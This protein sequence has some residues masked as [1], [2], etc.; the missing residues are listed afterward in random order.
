MLIYDRQYRLR[1]EKASALVRM[2]DVG[3]DIPRTIILTDEFDYE[4]H[5]NKTTFFEDSQLLYI[6][7]VY[8]D[9][10]YPHCSYRIIEGR[11][12]SRALRNMSSEFNGREYD[13]VIQPFL[14]FD[15][16][17]GV[18]LRDE[19]AICEQVCGAPVTLLRHGAVQ[20]RTIHYKNDNS[21]DCQNYNQKY[22]KMWAESDFIDVDNEIAETDNTG[23]VLDKL[24]SMSIDHNS[25]IYEWGISKGELIFMDMKTLP[26]TSYRDITQNNVQ[27]IIVH[28][29]SKEN[30]CKELVF[31]FPRFEYI[32]GLLTDL[33]PKV[34]IRNG[35]ALSHFCTYCATNEVPCMVRA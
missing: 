34:T 11:K 2:H 3:L 4:N 5:I 14:E 10:K 35:A 30:K 25:T 13:I 17:G 28:P 21:F 9:K 29:V 8:S 27:C 15:Y 33:A 32:D 23:T 24:R 31:D 6:R 1:T 26:M 19:L 22:K 7:F 12:L 18:L 20:Y 16:S